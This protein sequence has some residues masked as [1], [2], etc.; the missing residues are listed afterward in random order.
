MD[1]INEYYI[2]NDKI[3]SVMTSSFIY[4]YKLNG[5]IFTI[6]QTQKGVYWLTD[7]KRCEEKDSNFVK[8]KLLDAY[9]YDLY[10]REFGPLEEA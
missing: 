1:K 9:E 4:S 3:Y 7:G 8:D 6:Y 10:L 5:V 2:Y